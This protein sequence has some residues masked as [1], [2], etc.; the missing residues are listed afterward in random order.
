MR[1]L[2][3]EIRFQNWSTARTVMVN[4]LPAVWLV[5]VPLLPVVVPPRACSPGRMTW[6]PKN[7]PGFTTNVL[8]VPIFGGAEKSAAVRATEPPAPRNV[9]R[10]VQRPLANV[11]TFGEM[12]FVP[13]FAFRIA[14]AA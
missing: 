10:P 1:S 11:I 9:T 12:L 13:V 6:S 14:S 3:P 8:L 4:G 2:T 7:G 5:G